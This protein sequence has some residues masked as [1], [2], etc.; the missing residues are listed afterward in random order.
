MDAQG[1][2][3]PRLVRDN[4]N[5]LRFPEP[6]DWHCP[7]PGCTF[8]GHAARASYVPVVIGQH[9]VEAHWPKGVPHPLD[10]GRQ[11]VTTNETIAN[12]LRASLA[13]REAE[14]DGK[15]CA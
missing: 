7:K 10:F 1:N 11:R 9:V 2:A 3:Y 4:S 12:D 13:L 5:V 15:D 14:L 6:V 8:I